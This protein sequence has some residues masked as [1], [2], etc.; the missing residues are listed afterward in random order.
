MRY[1]SLPFGFSSSS[2]VIG[3][4]EYTTALKTSKKTNTDV[5]ENIVDIREYDVPYYVRAAID[6]GMLLTKNVA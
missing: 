4:E 5:M 2:V 3:Y 1:V 6:E